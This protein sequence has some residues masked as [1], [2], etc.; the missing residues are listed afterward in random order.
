L[1]D[2]IIQA[3]TSI[4]E[5]ADVVLWT[6]SFTTLCWIR[7]HK[8]WKTYV[9]N[10]VN[11]I[12][13][14]TSNYEWRHCLGELNPADLP[15]RRCSGRELAE[16]ETWW[17]GPKFLKKV[18]ICL[19]TCASTRAVYLELVPCLSVSSF[20]QAFRR[21]VSRRGLLSRLI[22][23]NAKTFKSASK[24]VKKILRSSEIQPTKVLFGSLFQI[25]PLKDSFWF[26]VL[27]SKHLLNKA[28][29]LSLQ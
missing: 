18:Y 16:A 5:I 7:N 3:L 17:N 26:W 4:K 10:R 14:L 12:R 20:L 1:V 13:E 22:T 15:S 19:F 24:E 25:I 6:D 29:L 8:A 28:L 23:D 9:Q 11:E 2:S 27:P 21:F